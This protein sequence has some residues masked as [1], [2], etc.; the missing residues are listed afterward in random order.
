M[1]D[2]DK[3]LISTTRTR[4][5]RL[6]AAVA[7]GTGTRRPVNTNVKRFIGSVV[8][9]AVAGVGCLGFSFVINLLDSQ[10]EEEAIAS[11]REAI[12]SAPIEPGNGFREDEDTGFLVNSDTGEIIDP[13]TGWEIDPETGMATDPQGR[14]VDP[15][16]NWYVDLETGYYTDPETGVTI[17]PDTQQVVEE[18]N[19][20]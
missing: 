20:E 14:T 16:T 19:E 15:R 6:A 5:N 18:E 1:I 11:Y 9:A 7:Y 13:K 8:L 4:R 2:H 12:A 17:D 10:K 3:T